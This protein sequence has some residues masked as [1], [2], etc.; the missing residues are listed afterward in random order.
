MTR[1]LKALGL[2]LLAACALSA[3]AASSA[4]AA[5][6]F[7]TCGTPQISSCDITGTGSATFGTKSSSLSVTCTSEVYSAKAESPTENATVTPTYSGCTAFGSNATV[8]TTGC[9]YLIRGSTTSTTNTSGGSRG[10]TLASDV[11]C[12]AGNSIKVTGAG[13]TI[14]ITGSA[15]GLNQ[16]LHGIKVDT[17]GAGTTDDLKLTVEVDGIHYTTSGFLCGAAGLPGTGTDGTLT[18]T[19]TAKGYETNN[20]NVHVAL[21]DHS[22]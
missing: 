14:S 8:D 16:G 20:H 11:R 7:I 1:T 10:N 5:T 4:S 22:V 3:V 12:T 21:T 18:G 13:C 19:A 2:A 9:T 17:E 15:G 6:D